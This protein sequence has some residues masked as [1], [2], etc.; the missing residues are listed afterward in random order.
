MLPMHKHEGLLF[1]AHKYC[2]R[3][4]SQRQKENTMA[5]AHAQTPSNKMNENCSPQRCSHS[6]ICLAPLFT[7]GLAHSCLRLQLLVY[8]HKTHL[9][10]VTHAPCI[11]HLLLAVICITIQP[12]CLTA[13]CFYTQAGMRPHAYTKARLECQLCSGW[14]R[15]HCHICPQKTRLNQPPPTHSPVLQRIIVNTK[16]TAPAAAQHTPIHPA[17]AIFRRCACCF[18]S[19]C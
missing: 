1:L 12:A 17:S 9:S 16:T 5:H 10:A 3:E 6:Y 7:D 14:Q 4:T 11:S 13:C 2:V 19:G 15:K 18:H 8:E